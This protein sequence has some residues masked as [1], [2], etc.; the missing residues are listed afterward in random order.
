[1]AELGSIILRRGTTA[2]RLAFVPQGIIYDTER[3]FLSETV[4]LWW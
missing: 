2:E 1:M 3:R 4:K